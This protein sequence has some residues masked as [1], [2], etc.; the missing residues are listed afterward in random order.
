M[1]M[2]IS[3]LQDKVLKKKKNTLNTLK[4]KVSKKRETLIHFPVGVLEKTVM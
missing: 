2:L 3:F 1:S 4:K